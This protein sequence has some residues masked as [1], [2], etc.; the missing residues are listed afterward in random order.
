M[1]DFKT[2][3]P[4]ADFAEV[5]FEHSEQITFHDP[6]AAVCCFDPDVCQWR[7]VFVKVPMGEGTAGWTLPKWNGA[8]DGTKPHKI[9]TDVDSAKFFD[10]YFANMK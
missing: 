2:L 8:D 7:D 5:W 1:R 6:L 4:V 10:L 9:A 3:A